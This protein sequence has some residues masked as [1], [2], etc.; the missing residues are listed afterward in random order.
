MT[1]KLVTYDKLSRLN[2][3]FV[4][5]LMIA[6]I[7]TGFYIF[8]AVEGGPGSIKGMLIGYHK[9]VGLLILVL[10]TLRV[11]HRLRQGFLESTQVGWQE[12]MARIMHWVLLAGI[13]VMPVSGVIGS[14]FGGRA[15]GFFGMS[16]IPAGPEIEGLKNLAYGIHGVFAFLIAAAV[17]LHVA[18][19]LKHHF[20]DRD[21]TMARMTGRV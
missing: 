7:I 10:G 4:A 11:I 5:L 13:V 20:I 15:T 3:W 14:F 9:S 2:H 18:G 21:D 19:A 16:A 8:R 17:L 1:S 12:T 6:M